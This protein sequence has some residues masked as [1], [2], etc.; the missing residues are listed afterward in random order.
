MKNLLVKAFNPVFIAVA[1]WNGI[2]F[3]LFE[4]NIYFKVGFSERK[5]LR[6]VQGKQ[7]CAIYFKWEV[8]TSLSCIDQRMKPNKGDQAST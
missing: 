2:Y 3:S 6:L 8:K 4:L 7:I 1:L 5:Y